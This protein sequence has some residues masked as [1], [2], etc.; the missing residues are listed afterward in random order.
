M[1]SWNTLLLPSPLILYEPNLLEFG[2][3]NVSLSQRYFLLA[4]V[5]IIYQQENIT[6][7][8][9]FQIQHLQQAF[10]LKATNLQ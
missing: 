7:D 3:I 1:L 5:Q 9:D 8:I 6:T 4:E 10:N 2:F